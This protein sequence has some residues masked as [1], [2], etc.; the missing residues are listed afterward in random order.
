MELKCGNMKVILIQSEIV[1]NNEIIWSFFLAA[2]WQK[3]RNGFQTPQC[4]DEG[5]AAELDKPGR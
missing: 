1:L 5:Q 4:V 2:L 3:K